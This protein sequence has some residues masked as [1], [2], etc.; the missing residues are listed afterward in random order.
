MLGLGGGLTGTPENCHETLKNRGF[1]D[2]GRFDEKGKRHGKLKR[3]SMARVY[4]LD[5]G[6]LMLRDISAP[7]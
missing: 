7:F 4:S 2:F 3:S 6:V 5:N 1:R